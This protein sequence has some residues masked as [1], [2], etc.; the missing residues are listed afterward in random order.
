MKRR[1][2]EERRRNRGRGR[3]E[4]GRGRNG[5]AK[6]ENTMMEGGRG[7]EKGRGEEG[8]MVLLT[9]PESHIFNA[10]CFQSYRTPA[11]HN[12]GLIEPPKAARGHVTS[13]NGKIQI[14]LFIER[15]Y[16]Y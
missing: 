11:V 7:R 12:Q 1:G 15:R 14:K 6:E 5:E 4:K 3:E 8:R 16:Y 10:G 13:V 9:L 2:R